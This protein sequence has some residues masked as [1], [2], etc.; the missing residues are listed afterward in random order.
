MATCTLADTSLDPDLYPT[1][2]SCIHVTGASRNGQSSL[3]ALKLPPS[4][5][6][7]VHKL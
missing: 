7:D 2:P 1:N 3:H 5:C 6:N 4:A